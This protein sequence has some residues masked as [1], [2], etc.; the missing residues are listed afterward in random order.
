MRWQPGDGSNIED[1]RGRRVVRGGTL[2][3]GGLLLVFALSYFTGID[4]TPLINSGSPAQTEV[5]SGPLETSP[6]EEQKKKFVDAVA[7]DTQETWERLLGGRYQRTR[8][9]LFRDAVESGCG[10]AQS[11][12]GP[13]YCPGDHK[14]YLDLGF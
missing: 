2:G 1:L 11:A 7:E 9:A 6:Q 10:V 4:F 3:V 13:F 12:T 8:V 5:A 14:V